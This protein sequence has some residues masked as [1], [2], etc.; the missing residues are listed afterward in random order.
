MKYCTITNNNIGVKAF[1]EG[2]NLSDN[3]IANNNDIGIFLG[4]YDSSSPLIQ[5]N[6]IYDNTNYNIL[7]NDS[8]GKDAKY[9]WWGTTFST[10]IDA[11]IWDFYDDVNLGIVNYSPILENPID[12]IP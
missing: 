10:D 12:I 9:N 5:Y 4:T 3:T 2:F 8:V 7:S 11:K 1:F 6:N